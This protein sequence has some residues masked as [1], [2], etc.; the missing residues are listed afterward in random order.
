MLITERYETVNLFNGLEN[1]SLLHISDVH[2]WFSKKILEKLESLVLKNN[3]DLIILTGDYYDLP[4]GAR[5]FREFLLKIS[6]RYTIV[7]IRGNHDFFYGSKISNLVLGIPNCHCVED[8][9]FSYTSKKGKSY[10]ISSWAQKHT[11]SKQDNCKNIVLIHNPEKLK[12]KEF[13]NIDLIL[14]G[15]LHGSQ[16][17]FFKTKNKTF[18]PGN[19]LYKY[20]ID[21]KQVLDTTIIISKGVGDTFPLRFNCPHEV[22]RITIQ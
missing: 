11:L 18:F 13:E 3:P 9:F 17:I 16:F 1:L 2:V 6:L 8:T 12:A 15:H 4:K 5:L 10:K 21:R 14:A 22:V 20:C 7:F 19:L